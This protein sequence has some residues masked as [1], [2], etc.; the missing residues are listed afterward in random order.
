LYCLWLSEQTGKHYRLPTSVEWLHAFALGSE[1]ESQ[2]KEEIAWFLDNTLDDEGFYKRAMKVGTRQPNKLGIH[3]MLGNASEWVSDQ[4]VVRGGNFLT[5][6]EELDGT[7]SEE[8]NQDIW[9]A[10]YP[11]LP[12]SIWWYKDADYV[13]FRIVCETKE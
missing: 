11:Q 12:K 1:M 7:H 5:D 2:E 3:D 8:E 4:P 10:N 13:G 6:A 9:N